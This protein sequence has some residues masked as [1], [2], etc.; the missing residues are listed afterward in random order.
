MTA[1]WPLI[2][3]F[4]G[5]VL[6]ATRPPSYTERVRVCVVCTIGLSR[7]FTRLIIICLIYV[8]VRFPLERGPQRTLYFVIS[9]GDQSRRALHPPYGLAPSGA[10]DGRVVPALKTALP[11]V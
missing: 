8:R 11:V 6:R 4:G 10:A 1:Q 7:L 2:R 5:Y 9:G 3:S